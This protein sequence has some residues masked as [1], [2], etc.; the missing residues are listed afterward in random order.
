VFFQEDA[1]KQ[2]HTNAYPLPE[3]GGGWRVLADPS[4]IRSLGGVDPEK[5][6]LAWE[7]NVRSGP[8]LAEQKTVNPHDER[9]VSSATC[10]S[11]LV[12][13]H[14]AI[15]GEWYQN[16]DRTKLWNIWSC[17]KSV[18]GTA[19]GI[20]F[21]ES[22]ERKLSAGQTIDLDS[23]AYQY[24]P[25][26][27]PLSDPRK[28]RIRIRHLLSMTSGI[29]GEDMGVF[30]LPHAKGCG[31]FELALGRCPTENGISVAELWGEPGTKWDYSDPAFAHLALILSHLTGMETE[32]YVRRRIF[33]PLGIGSVHWDRVGGEGH[34]GPHS[35]VNTSRPATS[36]ASATWLFTAATGRGGS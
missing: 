28:A 2:D 9:F 34:I 8:G 27:Y 16:G 3:S 14:G 5:L 29:K 36:L 33:Q 7:A 19:Y 22:R 35:F 23:M 32:E 30:G 6:A 26:G 31:P 20:L 12:V 21:Q 18:T 4:Q 13:R 15:V 1:M 17:T 24:I 10:S 11:V 25:Q